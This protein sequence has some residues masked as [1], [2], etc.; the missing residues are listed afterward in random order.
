M[1]VGSEWYL[2]IAERKNAGPCFGPVMEDMHDK[3]IL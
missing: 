2:Y 1:R 3:V